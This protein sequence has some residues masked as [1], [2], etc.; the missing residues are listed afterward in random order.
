M[1]KSVDRG[2][3]RLLREMQYLDDHELRMGVL[4]GTVDSDS[5][6]KFAGDR[7]GDEPKEGPRGRRSELTQVEV[8]LIHETG[9][10]V[11]K[12]EVIRYV[13]DAERSSISDMAKRVTQLVMNGK[14]SGEEALAFLG[15]HIVVKYQKRIL[16]RIPPALKESTIKQKTRND[17]RT[18][19]VPLV[20]YGQYNR[21][22]RY[23]MV[24]R[25]RA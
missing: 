19:T 7:R 9:L 8:F 12:R 6:G 11:P 13:M 20:L 22:F 25:G 3:N 17:G 21:S 18:A 2:M 15:E 4:S 1:A 16:N 14:L 5:M 23:S 24:R 10:G